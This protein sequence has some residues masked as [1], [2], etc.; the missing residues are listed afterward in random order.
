LNHTKN[1]NKG[2]TDEHLQ[3][4]ELI[5]KDH[6]PFNHKATVINRGNKAVMLN[7]LTKGMPSMGKFD[8]MLKFYCGYVVLHR[9]QVPHDFVLRNDAPGMG[10]LN[11]H[12]GI[13]WDDIY[14]TDLKAAEELLKECR[15]KH[16]A[17]SND[18]AQKT[19]LRS[20]G[21]KAIDKAFNYFDRKEDIVNWYDDQ[22]MLLDYN[23]VAY[24]FDCG[25][26][27]DENNEAL[28]DPEYVFKLT[29]QMELQI[30]SLASVW[31]Q[32]KAGGDETK[33]ILI[34]NII[35]EAFIETNP[36]L[37]GLLKRMSGEW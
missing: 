9:S 23:F 18:E 13:T 10:L 2:M 16:E 11:I 17:H 29:E 27:G 5:K 22:R 34:N 1:K 24:G 31:E 33:E 37:I 19:L 32:F 36:G 14:N 12:G 35:K 26:A 8:R 30:L 15:A 21:E 20:K 25:H 6:Y 7:D 4:L 28:Q 3:Q